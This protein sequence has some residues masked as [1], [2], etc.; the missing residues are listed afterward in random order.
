MFDRGT[1]AF[2]GTSQ[3][4]LKFGDEK[5]RNTELFIPSNNFFLFLFPGARSS[6]HRRS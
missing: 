6:G 2:V 3:R 5:T 1:K 4:I